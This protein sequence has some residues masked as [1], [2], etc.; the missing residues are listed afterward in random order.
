M[1]NE[2]KNTEEDATADAAVS[3]ISSQNKKPQ[4]LKQ[5]QEQTEIT[6]L[7]DGSLPGGGQYG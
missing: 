5:S 3:H 4:G 2:Q 6:S 1:T 7:P